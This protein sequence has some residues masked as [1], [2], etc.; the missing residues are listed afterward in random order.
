MRRNLKKTR[1]FVNDSLE[2]DSLIN[3]AAMPSHYLSSVMRLQSGDKIS[4]FNGKDG[5]W[6][7][8]LISI[9]KKSC[10][11]KI[12]SCELHQEYTAKLALLFSPIKSESAGYIVQK[13]TELGVT[14]IFPILTQR[15]VVRNVNGEKL[16]L[17]AIEAAEQCERLDVP[18]IHPLASLPQA[19]GAK[20][21]TGS[22][23]LCDETL[24]AGSAQEKL[25][26]LALADNAVLIGPEGGFT[27]EE[28]ALLHQLDY[29]L[30]ISLGKRILRAETAIV[31]AL[32][33]YQAIAGDW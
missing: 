29:V 28:L 24:L 23:I 2:T 17:S 19:L 5:Q 33:V 6:Q 4:V 3:L 7:A 8:E 32:S 25:R 26:N 9:H 21:F 11:L 15:S 18:V 31:A 20:E 1:L 12:Q 13:A 10:Q 14:D 16:K 27:L 22:L 30:P